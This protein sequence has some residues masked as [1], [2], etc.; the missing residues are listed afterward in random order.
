[1]R[2]KFCLE[3]SW[4]CY[5]IV[6]ACNFFCIRMGGHHWGASKEGATSSRRQVRRSRNTLDPFDTSVEFKRCHRLLQ[7]G[8][9]TNIPSGTIYGEAFKFQTC[10]SVLLDNNQF[11]GFL[12]FLRIHRCLSTMKSADSETPTCKPSVISNK[13][14]WATYTH[15][16]CIYCGISV[17]KQI[18]VMCGCRCKW[19][20]LYLMQMFFFLF[21]F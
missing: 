5:D 19:T 2:F 6:L 13:S 8:L 4:M 14:S 9:W 1:M 3:S 20:S 16:L 21:I 18:S 15:L 17:T 7:C 11:T 12:K 10:P